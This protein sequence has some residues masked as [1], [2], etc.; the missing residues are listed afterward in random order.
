MHME[1]FAQMVGRAFLTRSY[2]SCAY[3]FNC[4]VTVLQLPFIVSI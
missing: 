3:G 2:Y 4:K 1:L